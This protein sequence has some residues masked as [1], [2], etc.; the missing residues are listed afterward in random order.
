MDFKEYRQKGL[1]T[2]DEHNHWWIKT[3]FQYIDYAASMINQPISVIEYGC[4]TGQN[5]R[6]LR[7]YYRQSEKINSLTGVDINLPTN[8]SPKWMTKNDK[9][10]NTNVDTINGK[11]NMLIAMD[12]L[13]HIESDADALRAW[14]A[15]INDDSIVLI[16]VPA[17]QH[18]FSYHDRY[19][20]HHRR[21]TR[22]SLI[23]LGES[24]ELHSVKVMY[25]FSYLYPL[26]FF[27]R[28]VLSKISESEDKSDLKK[29]HPFVNFILYYLGVAEYKF[30][31]HIPFGT[32]VVGI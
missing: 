8:Y 9:F 26:V 1:T 30:G 18:L 15:N 27:I 3:R 28:K 10:I 5:L 21:Y 2:D 6:Y 29:T 13:E 31:S 12:V 14:V 23:K 11:S 22:K 19:M 4:G 16:T 20:G 25:I 7:E 24:A 32:S 17:M